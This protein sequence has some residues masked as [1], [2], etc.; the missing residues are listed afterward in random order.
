MGSFV[1]GVL[2][3]CSSE[4]LIVADIYAPLRM[5]P[6]CVLQATMLLQDYCGTDYMRRAVCSSKP[7][8]ASR[9]LLLPLAA[10]G[11]GQTLMRERQDV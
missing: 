1:N 9:M 10:A 2:V 8:V 4:S 6:S 3:C 11:P 5:E 7:A